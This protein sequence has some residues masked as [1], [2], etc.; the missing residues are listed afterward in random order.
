MSLKTDPHEPRDLATITTLDDELARAAGTWD[1]R[2]FVVIDAA[3]SVSFSA[4]DHHARQ[5]ATTLEALGVRP[6]D[7]VC[8]GL[9]NSIDFI[10]A[11][12]AV[13]HAGGIVVPLSTRLVDRELRHC[14]KLAGPA[15]MIVHS[16]VRRRN[17]LAEWP[18]VRD[19][20]CPVLV[21]DSAES[22]W[23]APVPLA[24]A[25]SRAPRHHGPEIQ[26][27]AVIM[28]SSGTT[29]APKGVI[30]THRALLRTALEV[31]R[32]QALGPDDAFFSVA[33]FFHCSGLMHA[34]LTTLVSGATLH[35]LSSF[36]A[37]ASV[38]T[39]SDAGITAAHGP[40]PDAVPASLA[41]S[42]SLASFDRAWTGGSVEHVAA[43]ERELGV[44]ACSLWGMTETCGCLALTTADDAAEV[45]HRTAG[46][47]MPGLEF[48]VVDPEGQLIDRVG[49][50]G[51][52]QV[53]GWNVTPGY[54]RDPQATAASF[55]DDGWLRTGDLAEHAPGGRFRFIGRLKEIIRVGGENVAPSE[56]ESVLAGIPGLVDVGVLARSEPRLGQVPV[57]VLVVAEG[58]RLDAQSLRRHCQDLLANFKV[59]R[60]FYTIGELPRTHATNRLQRQV[61]SNAIDTGLAQH[62]S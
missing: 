38:R 28:F 17:L 31:G 51:E 6:G 19:A 43:I 4:A 27:G 39:I 29:A 18:A 7:R 22:E 21:H 16:R 48:R 3:R 49:E 52:L 46:R 30:V 1:E 47:P 25:P 11:A 40:L 44:R 2:D 20:N 37:E 41:G 5:L 13:W 15:A 60:D 59:P 9:A 36:S 56:I 32:R 62:V 45:R 23:R 34:L 55:D 8:L 35:G 61:L 54:Y 50:R 53:R 58:V 57:A 12:F 24:G 42:V 26:D 14:L 33:P 10:V